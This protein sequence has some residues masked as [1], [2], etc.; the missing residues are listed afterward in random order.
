MIYDHMQELELSDTQKADRRSL[1]D[2]VCS[3]ILSRIGD[4]LLQPGDR[5]V[6]ARIAE[7]LKISTIPIREALRELIARRVLE[8]EPHKGARVREVS[9]PETIEAL[10]VKAALEGLAA[11]L[12]GNKLQNNCAELRKAVDDILESVKNHDYYRFQKCN[13]TF[14]SLIVQAAD[15]SVLLRLWES[16]AFEIRT[17][18]IMDYVAERDSLEIAAEHTEIVDALDE[19]DTERASALLSSHARHLVEYIQQQ[20]DD[21]K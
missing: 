10:Q 5:V 13:Q 4:G 16:L 21:L 14:H 15:N 6:E 9:I 3:L 1:R 17:R 11:P 19:G 2:Q 8:F 18:I 20:V 7:E 12:T